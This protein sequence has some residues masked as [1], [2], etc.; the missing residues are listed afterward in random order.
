MRETQKIFPNFVQNM[1]F[2]KPPFSLLLYKSGRIWTQKLKNL[3]ALVFSNVIFLNVHN[4]NQITFFTVM[5]LTKLDTFASINLSQSHKKRKDSLE[6][7]GVLLIFSLELDMSG[8][9]VQSI[10]QNSKK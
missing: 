8:V 6:T 2:L 5:I 1:A 9:V 4:L 10:H 7:R 3:K